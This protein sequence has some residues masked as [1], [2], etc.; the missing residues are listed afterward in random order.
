MDTITQIILA[1]ADTQSTAQSFIDTVSAYLP[2]PWNCVV[3][4]IGGAILAVF[5][6]KKTK[7][8]DETEQDAS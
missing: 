3:S 6:W 1:T 5:C 4:G 8:K 2:F 7:K